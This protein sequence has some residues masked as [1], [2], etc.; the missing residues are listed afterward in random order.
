[1]PLVNGTSVAA[2]LLLLYLSSFILLAILRIATGISIQRIGYFS[3][4]HISYAPREGLR[5]DLR[6]VGLSLRRP[7][8]AQPT[9]ISIVFE[10]LKITVDP[11]ALENNSAKTDS[12]DKVKGKSDED[13]DLRRQGG[14]HAGGKSQLWKRLT[15]IKEQVKRLHRKIHLLRMFDV[16]AYNT[17]AEI[18]GVGYVQI[19]TL[20]AAVYTRR[21][22]LD[23]GRLFR[24]KKDPLGDQKPAEW[25]FTVKSVQMGVGGRD[26]IEILDAMAINVHG[27]LYKDRDGLRDTSIAI[28]GGRVYVP[29]DELIHFSRKGRKAARPDEQYDV[30]SPVDEISFEDLA[31]E[32]GNPGSREAA[33]VQTVA[34][35][36]EFLRSVLQSVQEIQVGL[37]F[38]RISKEIVSLRQAN[39][40][41]VANVVIHEIGIDLHRLEQNSPAHRMYFQREDTAHQ[42]LLAALSISVSLDEDDSRPNRIMYIPMATITIR[43][44][45]PAKTMSFSQDRGVAERNT[46]ILFANLVVTSPSLDL[47]PQHLIKLLALSQGTRESRA[48]A[49]SRDHH[50]LISRLLPKASIKFSIHEPVLRFVLPVA[51]PAHAGPGEYDMIISSISSISLDVESSHSAGGE[52]LYSLGSS[53]RVLSHRL[54]Y[55]ASTGTTHNLILNEALELKVQLTASTT[56]SVILQGSLRTFS[57]LMVREEVSK[58]I[59]NIVR[60]FKHRSPEEAAVVPK[61]PSGAFLRKLPAWLIEASFEGSGCSLEVAGIDP[62]VSGQTRGAAFELESW[63]AH[64]TSAKSESGRKTK[65][66]KVSTSVRYDETFS[67]GKG[68]SPSTSHQK[69]HPSDPTDGRRLACHVKGFD[70]FIIESLDRWEPT[71][72][73]SIPRFE[74]AFSTSRDQQGPMFHIHSSI[75]AFYLDFS[76]Y[77]FY[78]IGVAGFVVKEAFVGPVPIKRDAEHH[79]KTADHHTVHGHLPVP[80]DAELFAIDVKAHYV[81]VKADMPHD[82]PMMLQIYQ[83]SGGRHRWSAPFMKAD[84]V[85]LHAE[86]P[87]LKRIWA[88][89]VS[90]SN[91]RVD[92]RH[93]KK[94][95]QHGMIEEKTI[96]ISTDFIRLGVPHGLQ[97]YRVFDNFINTS[98]AIQQLQHRFQTRSNEYVLAKHPVPPAKVP[99]ISVRSK[100]LCFELEDDPFE[101]KLGLIYHV[102]RIE[103]KQRLAREDAFRLKVKRMTDER[104]PRSSSRLRTQSAHSSRRGS[105]NAAGDDDHH[106]RSRSV[107]NTPRKRSTSRGRRGRASHRF[108]YDREGVCALT[109]HAKIDAREAWE[110]LQEHNSRS[111]KRRIDWMLRLQNNTV[112]SVRQ[113]FMGADEPPHDDHETETILGIPNRPGL[114]TLI[115]SDIHLIIDKPSFPEADLP[116]FLHEI[117]KGMPY[118][119][120]YGL[121]IPTSLSLDMGEARVFLRDYPLNLLHIPA[122]R[123]GQPARLPSW[124]LRTDF[125]IAEEFRDEKSIKHVKVEIVPKGQHGTHGEEIPAFA[126]DVRRTVAPVKTYSKPVIDINT[127]LPTTISWGTSYQPVIQDMMMIVESFTKPEI[128]PS[129]RVGFWDKIRLSFHSRLVV[130]WK[131]DGDVQ[132]RLKGTRDPYI[133]TGYGAGFVMC[134]RNDVQWLIH[135]VDDPRELMTVKSGEFILAIPDFSH[136]ARNT[137]EQRASN[138]SDSVST[139]SSTKNS[140]IFKKVIMKLSGNVQW[141]AGLVFERDLPDGNRTSESRHHY[142]VVLRNPLFL[143]DVDLDSYDAFRGFRS[144]HVH[145]SLAVAAPYDKNWVGAD[146]APS[147]S[148]NSVHL[149]PK[150]FSHFFSWW[151]TFSGVM[152]LPVRQGTLWR[153]QGKTSKKFGRHLATIKY[154]LLLSPLFISHV[155]KHKDAE[156][157]QADVVSATG[158]KIKID[159]FMLDLHQRREYFNT[160]AKVR[161]KQMRTSGMKIYKTELDFVRADLRAVAALI[162]GTTAEDIQNASDETLSSLQE[163][164][165]NIDLSQFTIP[166]QDLSW[167]DMDDFV[168]LDWVLPAESNPETKILPLAFTPRFTY[169]RQTDHGGA[170]QGDES[171]TSPFGDEDTHFCVMGRDNDPRKVQMNLIETRL[172]DLEDRLQTHVRIMNEHELLVVRE[173]D[174]DRAVRDKH[175]LLIAQQKELESKRRFLQH[176]LRRLVGHANPG[177]AQHVDNI[178]HA[179]G[180]VNKSTP[181][182]EGQTPGTPQMDMD[183]LYSAPHDEFASDFNNRFIIH[184]V[185]LKWNNSLRNIILRYSHQ[186]SQR[187]GFVYYMSRRAV[188][189]ILDIVDEQ[190]KAKEVRRRQERK[191]QPPVP[192]T[193]SIISPS[194]EKDEDSVVE[195]RIKQLLNDVKRFVQVHEGDGDEDPKPSGTDN[196]D[197]ERRP[198]TAD[199]GDKIAENFQAMNSYH[200]R[201]IAPQIQ[202]QSEKNTKAIVLISAKGMQLKVVS[203]MDKSRMSDDVSGLVQRRFALDMDG[204]QFFVATQKTLARYLHLYSGNRYGNTPGSSWPPWVSLEAMFDF[205]LEPFGFQRVIQKTSASLRYEKYNPLRLKYN[206]EVESNE[207]GE[208]NA[209][210]RR[211]HRIDQLWVD[212]PRVRARC[213]STQ[214]YAVYII[215][216]DLL[217]YSEPLEKTRSER[218]EKIMLASDFSDLRGAPEMA[219]SLQERIRQLEDIKLHFQIHAKYLDK[220]GWQDRINLEKDLASCEDELFFIMKAI[221]TSQQKSEDRKASQS[222]G[223]L[224]WYLSA[225][226]I[227]W[228]LMRDKDEPLLEFQLGN[229]A[230]ERVD[231]TDGSNHNA[232]EVEHIRGW[233]LLPNALYPEIIGPYYEASDRDRRPSMAGVQKM[234]QVH[235]YMLEAIAGIPVLEHFE[236]TVFPLKVQLERELGKKLFEYIFPGVGSNAFENG[237][238]SPLMVKNMEPTDDGDDQEF[239]E[240]HSALMSEQ[241][242][243]SPSPDKTRNTSP[244]AVA[245]RLKPTYGLDY[246]EKHKDSTSS[247][248]GKNRG[249][250]LTADHHKFFKHFNKSET[251]SVF[252]EPTRKGSSTS[253]RSAKK[254]DMSSTSL[255]ALGASEG[256]T[257]KKRFPIHRTGSKDRGATGKKD[258][259]DKTATANDDLSQMMSR[260]SNYM[261]LAHV[262]L[263]SFVVCLSYKGKSDR[264]FEDLHDFVFRM[265]TLEYRNKTWS[266]LDLALRLKKDVIRALIS[267]T[268][269]I[270]GNKFSHHRP[271]KKQV[272]RLKEIAHSSTIPSSD[273]TLQLSGTSDTTSLYS[274]SQDG[275]DDDFES[276]GISFQSPPGTNGHPKGGAFH[277]PSPLLRSGSWSSSINLPAIAA[278]GAGTLAS[279]APRSIPGSAGAGISGNGTASNT[280]SFFSR[281]RSAHPSSATSSNPNLN[282]SNN[283]P[284]SPQAPG[285]SLLK[286]TIGRHFSGDTVKGRVHF[287]GLSLIKSESHSHRERSDSHGSHTPSTKERERDNSG[288]DEGSPGSVVGGANGGIAPLGTDSDAET[289]KR[290]SVLMLGKKVLNRLS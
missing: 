74:T 46:N 72:F 159:S 140:A 185:Q 98:K 94:K 141:T 209:A 82:P 95:T 288:N 24:H 161:A 268:G 40:P 255:V 277:G 155:Y 142:D 64:Y 222:S 243:Q 278:T 262:K 164:P 105:P 225:S 227:V 132:L 153:D 12:Q 36:K 221:N 285:R 136:E 78:S 134:W 200:L 116:K 55:Q 199:L 100:A 174:Q 202:L 163:V 60:H 181:E 240:A 217:L 81:Q 168:E 13:A 109:S 179:N 15:N 194:E 178:P 67:S 97:M 280:T 258:K 253:L 31:E 5:I 195:D 261:T 223:L 130:N 69:H 70:G 214:Y 128:D 99:R 236:V 193:P 237:N 158:L 124:S 29:V 68:V 150:F 2:V 184:N 144:H 177:E 244:G 259:K 125:V 77:R 34:D 26:P 211:E 76:L 201:L 139:S 35:S 28:K 187:R 192:P 119:M 18:V 254:H 282:S 131:G 151:S 286:D 160:M 284:S 147:E 61:S 85:R 135:Q 260:A 91:V 166:D 6:G 112:K 230:Y 276:S 224:R 41:L 182:L 190:A 133:V 14:R 37:S 250:G 271:N 148:Y 120:K 57:I 247:L 19:S 216:L 114:M 248:H 154:N 44:T 63:S 101:W 252:K 42:A 92:L 281:P 90:I 270:I 30:L 117:G 83:V 52:L 171:R 176:G 273:V 149:S 96:D 183:G 111:W 106:R 203:I 129:E 229:A 84:L 239:V 20:T 205:H 145:L 32:L 267:H 33:I 146:S 263:N 115:I 113:L 283:S 38:V 198:S 103:Q 43:T 212:F 242:L 110:K 156:D 245:R 197:I 1:M 56:V 207:N 47:A 9:W 220:Q 219:E 17:S 269:A 53:F 22:L 232:L 8:F 137:P 21:K 167:I 108:R 189:F 80:L 7:T 256:G 104:R 175:E 191:N 162:A 228:H 122:I 121:L 65:G 157:Y 233:N 127:S 79:P 275:R 170:I 231:N 289:N 266:N 172:H 25:V 169:F 89:I 66:R 287:S 218:L 3:L 204:A 180:D 206:E 279:A 39:L 257:E 48:R 173:G 249:L 264:N 62:S 54:Y 215:V 50:R 59:Y 238:F 138:D 208:P 210:A 186:V 4:R 102:G 152:S 23:R 290:K 188:K 73:M 234:V 75:R 45:L 123:P 213:D 88:R 58:A 49:S 118:D 11:T 241:D 87:H 10:E 235:W 272:E 27:L 143:H 226:E 86:A 274:F 51:N 126:I 196:D 265:P 107:D 71:P 93:S 251:R 16:S 246:D 165:A